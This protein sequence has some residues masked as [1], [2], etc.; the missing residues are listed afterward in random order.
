MKKRER[1]LEILTFLHDIAHKNARL[2]K[3]SK[4]VRVIARLQEDRG[5]YCPRSRAGGNARFV[6]MQI[7]YAS[8]LRRIAKVT[9][10]A[11]ILN[12]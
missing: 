5:L 10:I 6:E 7:A 2:E 1:N 8:A 4:A 3:L 9:H 12:Q 11:R